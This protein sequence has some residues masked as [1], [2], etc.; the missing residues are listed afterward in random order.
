[1]LYKLATCPPASPSS[2]QSSL[3]LVSHSSQSVTQS[4]SAL[5]SLQLPYRSVRTRCEAFA[6]INLEI[7]GSVEN[8]NNNDLSVVEDFPQIRQ[9]LSDPSL[10]NRRD[11]SCR[12]GSHHSLHE[13]RHQSH[14]SVGIDNPFLFC[15]PT[16]DNNSLKAQNLLDRHE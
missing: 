3:H 2:P 15:G 16:L 8:N 9:R 14:A 10:R 5:I 13:H 12:G 6:E 11:P 4:N 1:M 7:C